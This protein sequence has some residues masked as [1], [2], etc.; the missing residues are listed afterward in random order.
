M[1]V[2]KWWQ[3]ISL[4]KTF[5]K[6]SQ[7]FSYVIMTGLLGQYGY[8]E[9]KIPPSSLYVSC[10]DGLQHPVRRLRAHWSIPGSDCL[11]HLSPSDHAAS[12]PRPEPLPPLHLSPLLQSEEP[13]EGICICMWQ[14][15]IMVYK[16]LL[17]W[18][19]LWDWHAPTSSFNQWN[20]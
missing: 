18:D 11:W 7:Y 10:V 14:T 13:V 1:R 8:H 9:S 5:W 16:L 2:S 3:S 4:S 19:V 6:M 20:R 15:I 17:N 12:S